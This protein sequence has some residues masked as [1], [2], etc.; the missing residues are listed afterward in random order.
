MKRSQMLE[1]IKEQWTNST[2]FPTDQAVAEYILKAIEKAGMLPP[3]D[4]IS[5]LAIDGDNGI[6]IAVSYNHPPAKDPTNGIY[7]GWEDEA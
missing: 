4:D 1:I 2:S 5:T 3:P 7:Q 6:T